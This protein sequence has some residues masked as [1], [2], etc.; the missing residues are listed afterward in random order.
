V[1]IAHLKVKIPDSADKLPVTESGEKVVSVTT[2]RP[3][4]AEEDDD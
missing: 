1:S 3:G 4:G 2:G